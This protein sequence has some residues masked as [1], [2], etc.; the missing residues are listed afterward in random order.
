M[1]CIEAILEYKK[2]QGERFKGISDEE[3]VTVLRELQ[4]L[5]ETNPFDYNKIATKVLDGKLSEISAKLAQVL[6]DARFSNS[7][8]QRMKAVDKNGNRVFKGNEANIILSMMDNIEQLAEGAGPNAYSMKTS[9]I[10]QRVASLDKKLKDSGAYE[11]IKSRESDSDI[12]KALFNRDAS[13]IKDPGIRAAVEIGLKLNDENLAIKRAAGMMVNK[14]EQYGHNQSWSP[15]LLPPIERYAEFE[16]DAMEHLDW[17]KIF[18]GATPL[19]D[20]KQAFIKEWYMDVKTGRDSVPFAWDSGYD[21]AAHNNKARKIIMKDADSFAYMQGKYNDKGVLE[22]WYRSIIN[23]SRDAATVK[24]LGAKPQENIKKAI[25]LVRKSITDPDDLAKFDRK[26]GLIKSVYQQISGELN[27]HNTGKLGKTLQ[28]AQNLEYM[29]SMSNTVIGGGAAGDWVT[30]TQAV[31]AFG[32]GRNFFE[33]QNDALSKFI[34]SFTNSE[35]QQEA[36]RKLSVALDHTSYIIRQEL[37]LGNAQTLDPSAMARG[38]GFIT[39]AVDKFNEWTG[40]RSHTAASRANSVTLTNL[41]LA[42]AVDMP[43]AS[44]DDITRANIKKHGFTDAKW[45]ALKHTIGEFNGE[46]AIDFDKMS[47]IPDE[48]LRPLAKQDKQTVETFRAELQMYLGSYFHELSMVGQA[49]TS[50]TIRAMINPNPNSPTGQMWTALMQFK[51]YPLAWWWSMKRIAMSD[52]NAPVN[53]VG[54]MVRDMGSLGR[55]SQTIL[56]STSLYYGVYYLREKAQGRKADAFSTKRLASA[57]SQS[58]AG[59]IYGD[60]IFNSVAGKDGKS[61]ISSLAGPTANTFADIT[62][63]LNKSVHGEL[64]QKDVLKVLMDQQWAGNSVLYKNWLDRTTYLLMH[65]HLN[66]DSLK[67]LE[68]RINPEKKNV[69]DNV[70][71]SG[72]IFEGVE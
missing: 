61:V 35:V 27:T 69:R 24:A 49:R 31:R 36:A 39:N 53:T 54:D 56:A 46:K 1:N 72:T 42:E 38:M 12:R 17:V 65:D 32:D 64:K 70:L 33:V 40:I 26:V 67:M 52:P 15:E 66:R 43:F 34:S 45:D 16:A 71:S 14:L 11:Q 7:L 18:D 37:G 4:G 68:R 44:L 6:P 50:P 23:S 41:R 57:F 13:Q 63:I 21:I 55:I 47:E 29:Q 60:A 58:G 20:A 62:S 3:I 25:K 5:K 2:Q 22:T 8:L 10:A 9:L 51:S 28:V 30:N 48:V 19:A 59:L